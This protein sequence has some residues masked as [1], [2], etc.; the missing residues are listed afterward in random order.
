MDVDK[1]RADALCLVK[2]GDFD[3]AHIAD[4]LLAAADEIERGDWRDPTAA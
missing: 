4:N 3:L 2:A 1:L